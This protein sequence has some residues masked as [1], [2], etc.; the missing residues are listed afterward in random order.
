MKTVTVTE[1]RDNIKKYLLRATQEKLIVHRKDESFL[2]VPLKNYQDVPY[3]DEFVSKILQ[4]K[5]DSKKGLGTII[6]PEDLKDL[7]K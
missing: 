7:W 1:F 2:I 3:D 4:A 6:S 5:E